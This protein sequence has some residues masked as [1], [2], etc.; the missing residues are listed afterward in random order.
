MPE[1][2]AMDLGMVLPMWSALPFAG[3]LLSIATFPLLA[4]TFW[5]HHYPKVSAAWAAAF[6]IP[7]LLRFGGAAWHELLHV[8]LIDYVPFVILLASLFTIGGGIH[9]RGTLRGSPRLNPLIMIARR[10]VD[11]H[12]ATAAAGQP[13]AALP[14]P[15]D[16]VL[17]LPGGEHRRRADSAGRSSAL[18]RLPA[19]R[20]LPVDVL[21]LAGDAL[22]HRGGPRRLPAGGRGVLAARDRRRA[23]AAGG[24]ARAVAHRGRAQPAAAGRRRGRRHRVGRLAGAGDRPARRPGAR[25]QHG[26]RRHAAAHAAPVV[27]HD[28]VQ[29][30]RR[31]RVLL[32]ADP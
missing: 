18:P 31:Q 20:A 23:C 29:R 13:G 17:H 2:P 4:P 7:F 28:V 27:A 25:R 30:A 3:F 22:R 15:H 11:G 21:A 19:R 26:P 8:A 5:H 10:R 32:G 12:R 9:V 14:G 24:G 6:A 1:S 16:G